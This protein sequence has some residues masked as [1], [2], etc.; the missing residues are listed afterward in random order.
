[1]LNIHTTHAALRR[2]HSQRRSAGCSTDWKGHRGRRTRLPPVL[3]CIDG[4]YK[5]GS[6]HTGNTSKSIMAMLLQPSTSRR[7]RCGEGG[8]LTPLCINP[9][10]RLF[11]KQEY[12]FI[13]PICF[14]SLAAWWATKYG[15]NPV[16]RTLR[17]E[18]CGNQFTASFA[19][20][21]APV[22]RPGRRVNPESEFCV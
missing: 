6:T 10:V 5:K 19:A 1:M 21:P 7:P 8:G 4:S 13:C 11:S 2:E 3:I 15:V 12:E 14:A 9:S 17:C 16:K 18:C 22:S 20:P